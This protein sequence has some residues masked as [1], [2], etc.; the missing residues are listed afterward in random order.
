MTSKRLFAHQR[1]ETI[2]YVEIQRRRQ[3]NIISEKTDVDHSSVDSNVSN[4]TLSFVFTMFTSFSSRTAFVDDKI[5][6]TDRKSIEKKYAK[7][8]RESKNEK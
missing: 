7:K 6:T 8:C 1:S 5:F 3:L 2:A 4:S